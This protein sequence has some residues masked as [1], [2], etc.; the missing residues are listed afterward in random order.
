MKI[1]DFFNLIEGGSNG[2]D[3]L[4]RA[5]AWKS[6]K[7]WH[8]L[9]DVP[10][11][12][13]ECP[14]ETKDCYN[15]VRDILLDRVEDEPTEQN[16]KGRGYSPSRGAPS[17]WIYN[18]A[19]FLACNY[20]RDNLSRRASTD[21]ESGGRAVPGVWDAPT[22]ESREDVAKAMASLDDRERKVLTMRII[23][24]LGVVEVG[25][26]IGVSPGMVSQIFASAKKKAQLALA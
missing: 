2:F 20:K 1:A 16:P 21:T 15:H 10:E 19:W 3:K 17:T 26:Q 6:T 18:T 4:C 25:Q 23:D 14:Q 24:G 13:E 8:T 9:T 22:M 7:R 11:S 5:V 12:I